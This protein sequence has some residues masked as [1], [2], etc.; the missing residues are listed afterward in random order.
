MTWIALFFPTVTPLSTAVSNGL[1]LISPPQED[2]TPKDIEHIID[3]LKAGR[4]PPPGPRYK[5]QT[6]NQ[7]ISTF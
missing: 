3:E 1:M 7:E 4:V 6:P 5:Q 2:L